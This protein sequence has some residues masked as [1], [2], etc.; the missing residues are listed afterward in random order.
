MERKQ[1]IGYLYNQIGKEELNKLV[2][3]GK[4]TPQEYLEVVGEDCQVELEALKQIKIKFIDSYKHEARMF[5]PYGS[6]GGEQRFS[7][8][9]ILSITLGI[10]GI[11]QGLMETTTWKYSNGTYEEANLEYLQG[12]LIKGGMLLTKCFEVEAKV[13]AQINAIQDVEALK[14]FNEKEEFDKLFFEG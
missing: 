4:I 3:Q 10:E 2:N 5:F 8:D 12:M 9:D 13:V 14:A 7:T 1:M 6:T 11:K